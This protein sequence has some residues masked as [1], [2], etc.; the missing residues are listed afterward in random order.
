MLQSDDAPLKDEP[1]RKIS[2]MHEDHHTTHE[3]SL[4]LS[5]RLVDLPSDDNLISTQVQKV[6]E[7]S[8]GSRNFKT[9]GGGGPGAVEFLGLGFVLMPLNTYPM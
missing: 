3:H 7:T 9:G 2:T 8:G 1:D 5:S 6:V 4:S